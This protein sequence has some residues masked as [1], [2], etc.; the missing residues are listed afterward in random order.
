M[1]QLV[2][3]T[4]L[5]P[6]VPH[7]PE[8]EFS[9]WTRP[10]VIVEGV[11]LGGLWGERCS[12]TVPGPVLYS[13]SIHERTTVLLFLPGYLEGGP[14]LKSHVCACTFT[15]TQTLTSIRSLLYKQQEQKQQKTQD[16]N[17]NLQYS[18]ITPQF[19]MSTYLNGTLPSVMPSSTLALLAL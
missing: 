16:K 14:L 8:P 17:R 6:S 5:K 1:S 19:S 4:G 9:G 15:Y 3:H 18:K 10:R 11:S 2:Q 13:L 7:L 12:K